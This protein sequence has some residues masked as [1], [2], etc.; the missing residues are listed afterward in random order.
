MKNQGFLHKR[1]E[2]PDSMDILMMCT[3]NQNKKM[4]CHSAGLFARH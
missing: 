1:L 4:A 3:G 2:A